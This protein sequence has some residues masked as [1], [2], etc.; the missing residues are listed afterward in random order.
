MVKIVANFAGYTPMGGFIRNAYE[1]PGKAANAVLNTLGKKIPKTKYGSSKINN[2]PAAL[3]RDQRRAN[4]K[5]DTKLD[6]GTEM[7]AM[8]SVGRG[9][10]RQQ[11]SQAPKGGKFV[12]DNTGAVP[13]NRFIDASGTERPKMSVG[14]WRS[15][16]KFQTG[17]Y[18]GFSKH[19]PRIGNFAIFLGQDFD[20]DLG[21]QAFEALKQFPKNS[22]PQK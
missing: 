15:Q 19:I 6:R 14:Q 21:E 10:I 18:G 12:S 16:Q 4:L 13:P 2:D 7:K 17:Q 22:L 8:Q 3:T 11:P 1:T 20:G 9:S 5:F